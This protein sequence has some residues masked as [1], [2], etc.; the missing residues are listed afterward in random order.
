MLKNWSDLMLV[1]IEIVIV[2]VDCHCFYASWRHCNLQQHVGRAS[3][4]WPCCYH[5]FPEQDSGKE[6][7]KMG[8]V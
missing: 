6:E 4:N 1:V 7:A 2:V 3:N 8:V 5:C